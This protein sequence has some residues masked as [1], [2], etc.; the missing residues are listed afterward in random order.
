MQLPP[1]MDRAEFDR[2]EDHIEIDL[3]DGYY[4]TTPIEDEVEYF[5]MKAIFS[6]NPTLSPNDYIVSAIYS[7]NARLAFFQPGD[8]TWT[9]I[10]KERFIL[11]Y[12]VIYYKGQIFAVD[13]WSQ[14]I[15]VDLNKRVG[16]SK[17]PQVKVIAP[18]NEVAF[19]RT[20]LVESSSG[21]LLFVQR[22]IGCDDDNDCQHTTSKFKVFKLLL[23]QLEEGWP[24]QVELKSLGGDSLFLEDNHSIC[25]SASK[26]PGCQPNSIYYSDDYIDIQFH[27][28]SRHCDIDIFNVENG[29]FG[30]HYTLDPSHKHMPPSIW[31]VPTMLG[32]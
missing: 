6:T 31:I 21:D 15:M 2:V 19:E 16:E 7:D 12:D 1:I 27:P 24:K 11:I 28:P 14:I 29:S 13:H 9:Y 25:V 17:A 18:R 22:F 10:D 23:E 20:Y 30:T 3:E 26:W 32:N 5:V 8:T 4:D